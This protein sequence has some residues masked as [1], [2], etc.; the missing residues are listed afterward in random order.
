M[1]SD[2]RIS[3]IV[4]T[5]QRCEFVAQL[6]GGLTRQRF[7]PKLF[8]VLICIDGSTDG[9]Q[10]LVEQFGASFMLRSLWQ[11]NRGR[12]AACNSGIRS[13]VGEVVVLLDDDMDPTPGLLE[14]H[15]MAHQ[16][17]PSVA[18]LGAAPILLKPSS[19]AV[20]RYVAEK[21][22]RHLNNLAQPGYKF[23]LRDFYSGNCSIRRDVLLAVGGFDETFRIYGN[24]DL[25]LCHRLSAIGVRL[26]YSQNAAAYQNYTKD[27]FGLAHDKQEQ[28]CTAVL[29]A[30]KHPET[31]QALK[32]STY[33]QASLKWR[34]VRE[35]LLVASRLTSWTPRLVMKSMNWIAER[36]PDWFQTLCQHAIDYFYWLGAW[37]ALRRSRQTFDDFPVLSQAAGRGQT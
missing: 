18:V 22:N 29:L 6:L 32:L 23:Q 19:S 21:F 5:Y 8:E 12:A 15:W 16:G 9:T 10:E 31:F 20:A 35:I 1:P 17:Q 34:I 11:P 26:L 2:I 37:S 14:G 24:E 3:M 36:R 25:E 27:F 33:R 30:N 7:S 4:P 28:G 13:A